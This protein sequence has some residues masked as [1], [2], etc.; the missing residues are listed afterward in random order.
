MDIPPIA[1]EIEKRYAFINKV[2]FISIG[3]IFTAFTVLFQ[4]AP[5]F[6]PAI[7]LLFS[8]FSTLP[9]A[10]AA[11]YNVSL[12]MTVFVSSAIIL[13]LVNLQEAVILL[14]TTGPLG[15]VMGALLYRKGIFVSI[16]FSTIIL[17]LGMISL[18]Y[19]VGISPFGELTD[20]Q[21]IP[22]TLVIFT[23]FSL[24]YASIWNICF[25]KLINYLIKIRLLNS[26]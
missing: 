12:G 5:L 2:R 21:S 3:G 19:I 1:K 18:T 8:P 24:I 14:F 20:S 9:I 15:V 10:I 25:R 16:L 6:F 17:S 11:F 4:S 7:G 22:L 13:T 23:S 26:P